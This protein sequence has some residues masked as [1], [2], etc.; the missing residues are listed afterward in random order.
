MQQNVLR[1]DV[2]VDHAVTV[3]VVERVGHFARDA[4]GIV[5]AELR[6]AVQFL[7]DRL[8]LDVGHDIEQERVRGT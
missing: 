5:H 2:A 6:F 7:A 8:A 3:R 4:H 1:L